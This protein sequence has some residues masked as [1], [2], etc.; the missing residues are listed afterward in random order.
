[1]SETG[2]DAA[3]IKLYHELLLKDQEA[4]TAD[5]V[6]ILSIL[7]RDPC[8]QARLGEPEGERKPQ[9]EERSSQR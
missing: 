4:L 8:I 9:S 7:A 6:E 2:L 3:K 5:E 1:M